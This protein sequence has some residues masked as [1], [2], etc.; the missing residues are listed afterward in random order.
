M[1][2]ATTA[3][4]RLEVARVQSTEKLS[5]GALAIRFNLSYNTVRKICIDYQKD[6]ASSLAPDYSQ[7]GRRISDES[8]KAYR[9]VRLIAHYHQDWGVPYIITK[10][11]YVFPQLKLQSIRTYQRRLAKQGPNGPLPPP[12]IP[13]IKNQPKVRQPHDEWQIDAKERI[14]LPSGIEV[15]Y[16]NIT[17]KKSHGLLKAKPFPPCKDQ[18]S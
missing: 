6:G 15:C 10:I 5:Y 8:E 9:L 2:K 7:C 13:K 18:F 12:V 4:L 17:D 11:K 3:S 14:G 16:L 1:G